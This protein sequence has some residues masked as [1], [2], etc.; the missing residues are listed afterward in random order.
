MRAQVLEHGE[1]HDF[2]APFR[3]RDG[4][5]IVNQVFAS[6]FRTAGRR[7]ALIVGRDVTQ[8]ERTRLLQQAILNNASIGI[9]VTRADRFEHVN[10]MFHAMLGWGPGELEGQSTEVVWASAQ[11]HLRIAT[12]VPEPVPGALLAFSSNATRFDNI[13][14][15]ST[16]TIDG[17]LTAYSTVVTPVVGFG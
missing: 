17:E 2:Q 4:R 9:A 10:P 8:S 6:L 1:T 15:T 11:E 13:S 3:A 16:V 7:Y 5:V 14:N 12:P